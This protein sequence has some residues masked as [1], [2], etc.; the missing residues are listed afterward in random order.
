MSR[1]SGTKSKKRKQVRT[2]LAREAVKPRSPS[3]SSSEQVS[4]AAAKQK[5]PA[6]MK[7]IS[8]QGVLP[9]LKRG[10]IIAGII[11]GVL[12]ILYLLLR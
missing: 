2:T 4:A 1:K 3:V 10:S 5:V 8:Y 9:E 12:V 11:F 6:A 7:S